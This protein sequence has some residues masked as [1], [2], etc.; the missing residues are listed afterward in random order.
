MHPVI[1][2]LINLE[3]IV[4]QPRPLGNREVGVFWVGVVVV[5]KAADSAWY[6]GR[7]KSSEMYERY[8]W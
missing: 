1:S 5:E 8:R 7:D 2:D 4:S 6:A 3:V